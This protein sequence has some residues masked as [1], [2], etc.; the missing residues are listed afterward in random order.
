[1]VL[2]P[3]PAIMGPG[4]GSV[5]QDS[6][7]RALERQARLGDVDAEARLINLRIRSGILSRVGVRVAAL[8]GSPGAGLALGVATV[9]DEPEYALS[10]PRSKVPAG[11]QVDY[12]PEWI[13]EVVRVG[14]RPVAVM[15]AFA[16]VDAVLPLVGG[17]PT[18]ARIRRLLGLI[19]D[20]LRGKA[21]EDRLEIYLP[22]G[23][24]VLDSIERLSQS[25][26]ADADGT[27][28]RHFRFLDFDLLVAT[29]YAGRT[30][31]EKGF[32]LTCWR[33]MHGAEHSLADATRKQ[34]KRVKLDDLGLE[35]EV[36]RQLIQIGLNPDAKEM[37]DR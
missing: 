17:A 3:P 31:L 4:S 11:S 37:F 32:A 23:T 16:A 2:M 25:I 26:R 8:L 14:G 34:R 35:A 5:A 10:D 21:N 7:L 15:I 29:S 22:T 18:K 13:K 1:M 33:A 36:K 6:E 27:P 28:E 9:P 24:F 19:G 20:W 12:V 30:V